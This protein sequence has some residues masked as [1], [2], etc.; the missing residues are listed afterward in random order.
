M[1]KIVSYLS[2]MFMQ[3]TSGNASKKLLSK[4]N[5][6]YL[7]HCYARH[8]GA[9]ILDESNIRKPIEPEDI[10][11][12]WKENYVLY[13]KNNDEFHHF[14][15]TNQTFQ[16]ASEE[17]KECLEEFVTEETGLKF[18]PVKLVSKIYGERKYYILHFEKKHD[19]ID[20]KHTFSV[21]GTP[22]YACI[23]L[24]KVGTLQVFM[25]K[26]DPY[27]IYVTNEVRKALKKRNL[28]KG[29]EFVGLDSI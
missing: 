22:I 28:D 29:I 9:A 26:Q 25:I 15:T 8:K 6:F 2:T 23:S 14:L 16:I 10:V 18:L 1:K 13:L 27:F 19:V 4:N 3:I 24:K 12:D 5:Y 21:G 7:S 11:T 17:F 20:K